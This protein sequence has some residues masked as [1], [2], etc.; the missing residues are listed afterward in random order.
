MT[1]NTKRL[2]DKVAVIAG[3]AS[4]I[5]KATA[6]RFAQEGASIAIWDITRSNVD[7]GADF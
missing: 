7:D 1:I 5:S 4:G 3:G 2:N 6:I